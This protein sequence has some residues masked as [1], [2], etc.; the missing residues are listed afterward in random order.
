MR[1]RVKKQEGTTMSPVQMKRVGAWILAAAVL[2]VGVARAGVP[3]VHVSGTVKDA[4]GHGWPLYAR[5]EFTSDLNDPNVVYTDP[6]SGVYAADLPDA[7]AYKVVVT[8]VGPGYAPGGGP[9]VTAGASLVA[10][11][12]LFASALCDAPGYGPGTYGPP[13]LSESFDAGVIPPG[14]SVETPSGMSWE[15]R[16]GAD[17]CGFF[18]GNQTG[19]SGPYALVNS[20]CGFSFDDTYLLTPTIDLSSSPNAAIR[21]A[22]A[23]ID[24][25]FGDVAEVDVTIDGGATWTNVWKAPGN[26]P[27]PGTVTADMSFAAGHASVQARFH[28]QMFFG[29]WWQV[30]DVSIG[31][32]ACPGLAGGLV[33]GT[34]SDTNTGLG[35]NGATVTSLADGSF[36]TTVAAPGQGNGFYSLFAAGSGSRA[37]EA[38]AKLLTSLTKNTAV[39]LDSVGRLDFS[40][41]AGILTAAPATLSAV[42]STGGVLSLMLDVTNT[43]TGDGTFVLHEVDV[44]PASAPVASKPASIDRPEDRRAARRLIPF[45]RFSAWDSLGMPN[46]PVNV[47]LATGAGNLVSSFPTG[48]PYAYGLAYDTDSNRLWISSSS[49]DD[50]GNVLGDGLDHEYTPAGTPTDQT[51]DLEDAP[52]PWQGDGTYN[53]RTGMI[54]QTGIAF[55][56]TAGPQ[57]LFEIDPVARVVT[58]NQICGPW[59]NFPPIVG[60]AY[61]YATD[62]YY[63]GDSLGGITHVDSAGN[64]RDSGDIGDLQISGLAYNPTSR[65]LYVG[66]YTNNPYDIWLAD[67]AAGYTVF[68]GFSVKSNGI[69]VLNANGAS[70]ESDCAGHL[71]VYNVSNQKVYE[72]DSGDR[73]WCV[74]EI[75]WLSEDP[76]SATVPGSGGGSAQAGAGNTLPVTVTFDSAGL[77]PGLRRRSLAFTTD[78][79]DPVA[80]VPVDFTVLFNDVPVDSFAWNYIYG[81]AGAGVMPGCAPNSPTFAFCPAQVVTRRAMAGYLERAVHGALTPP[82]VYPG[83]FNDVLLGSYN[84]DYIQGLVQ[85]G[86]TVGCNGNPPL[87]CPESPATRAQMAVFVWKGEHGLEPPPSCTPPGTF[88]D[89]PCPGGFAVDYI[90]GIYAEKITAGCGTGYYCPNAGITNAQLAVFLVKAFGIPYLP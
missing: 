79:P 20:N 52:S 35:L 90:E 54:W 16:T 32:F 4:S 49:V 55:K 57:C 48:L 72:F 87:F 21:W 43:G 86:I 18:D 63:V 34:V 41:A 70:L 80:P 12:T 9:I 38:S 53:A 71:W 7:T 6:V 42:V 78:T 30:D 88:V 58:G 61:D 64:L 84:S 33:V 69:P 24:S 39:T 31:P 51:I 82:P 14:W 81:A 47:P 23:F 36:A 66:T 2:G 77:A 62:T 13:V 59:G 89:V 17:P 68:G 15:V 10:N 85:D 8:A 27:G 11:W 25:G 60:L 75:P 19:G 65:I 67:P 5:L 50:G 56:T 44:P 3:N 1:T 76:A 29:I 74:A 45:G 22:N 37:F 46:T 28:Y 40:L 26:L 83:E 73:G